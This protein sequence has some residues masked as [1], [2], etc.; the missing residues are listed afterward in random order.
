MMV[1]LLTHAGV[2]IEVLPER[3]QFAFALRDRNAILF[4]RP[5][6]SPSSAVF[7]PILVPVNLLLATMTLRIG[8]T[9]DSG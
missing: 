5:E 3:V 4:G 6:T 2:D 1:R 8:G 7:L 9:A